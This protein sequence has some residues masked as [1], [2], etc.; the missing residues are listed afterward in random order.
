MSC[1]NTVE[2]GMPTITVA[3]PLPRYHKMRVADMPPGTVFINAYHSPDVLE[4]PGNRNYSIYMKVAARNE[5]FSEALRAR[6]DWGAPLVV[7]LRN[8]N[9]YNLKTKQNAPLEG[10]VLAAE[11]VVRLLG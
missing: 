3:P 4:N 2:V 10:Y 1:R 11:V 5:G 6:G 9:A 8:G 7:N